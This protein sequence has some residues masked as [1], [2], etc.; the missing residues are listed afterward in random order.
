MND[1]GVA[2][3]GVIPIQQ[4]IRHERSEVTQ[5]CGNFAQVSNTIFGLIFPLAS[6]NA[7][8]SS[9]VIRISPIPKSPITAIRKSNP[10]S[11]SENPNVIRNVPVT[12]S[13]P[14]A[15]QDDRFDDARLC[16]CGG[17]RPIPTKLQ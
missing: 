12:V 3:P 8:P 15:A 6:L 14:T 1:A 7:K 9:I 11:I 13:S 17:S 16:A 2:P 5:Y 10:C 4:P